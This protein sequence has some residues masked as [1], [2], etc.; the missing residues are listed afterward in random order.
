MTALTHAEERRPL[1]PIW[2]LATRAALALVIWA[3]ASA[4]VIM[5]HRTFDPMSAPAAAVA[6]MMVILVAGFA[7]ARL[8]GD[9]TIDHALLVGVAWLMLSI[10]VEVAIAT[11][12][13]QGWF[14]L[15]GAPSKP[16]AR[17]ILL[18]TWVV[19]PALC[20]RRR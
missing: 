12:A 3:I 16:Y 1:K 6:K 4:L 9:C 13:H 18:F 7:Y 14:D 15:I 19:A 5:A 11:S 10:G 8:A 2:K 17:D 20:A